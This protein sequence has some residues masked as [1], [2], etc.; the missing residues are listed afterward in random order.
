MTKKLAIGRITLRRLVDVEGGRFRNSEQGCSGSCNT[1]ENPSECCYD[2]TSP[3][4]N[5]CQQQ[6]GVW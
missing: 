6:D 2:D 1:C 5:L 4:T 3:E